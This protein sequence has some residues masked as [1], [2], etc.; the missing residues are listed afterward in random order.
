MKKVL[1]VLAVLSLLAAGQL[2]NATYLDSNWYAQISN[3]HTSGPYGFSLAMPTSSTHINV[4]VSSQ[5]N[6]ALFTIPQSGQGLPGE[7]AYCWNMTLAPW[8]TMGSISFDF[9]TYWTQPNLCLELMQINIEDPEFE[10]VIWSAARTGLRSNH[11][12]L[13]YN[14]NGYKF[15]LTVLPEVPEPASILSLGSL[16]GVAFAS[17]LR[18]RSKVERKP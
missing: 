2:A 13:N 16:C 11:V 3:V 4:S 18:R 14:P 1:F 10:Q 12:T 15:K 9:T 17:L 6:S 8:N 5:T 7:S